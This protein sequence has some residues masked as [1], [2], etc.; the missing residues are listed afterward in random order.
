MPL[1]HA[2]YAG[3]GGWEGDYELRGVLKP[4]VFG[5]GLRIQP[6]CVNQS[7][8]MYQFH[9]L[10]RAEKLLAVYLNGIKLDE[11]EYIPCLEDGGFILTFR[12]AGLVLCD[13]IGPSYVFQP[14]LTGPMT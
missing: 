1:E 7:L 3:T 2:W 13:A 6:V 10:G 5:T 14:L 4:I 12:L 8:G 11:G 9:G